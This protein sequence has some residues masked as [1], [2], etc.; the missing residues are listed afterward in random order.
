MKKK[1]KELAIDKKSDLFLLLESIQDEV[2]RLA[3][4]FYQKTHNKATFNSVLDE[5]EG[6]GKKRKAILLTYFETIADIKNASI[7]KLKSLGLPNDVAKNLLEK[8]KKS[9]NL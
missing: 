3:I 6:I 9:S 2:H 1:F 4:T 8:L 5:V 7:D